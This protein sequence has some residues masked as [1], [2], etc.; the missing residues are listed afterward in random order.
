MRACH[1]DSACNGKSCSKMPSSIQSSHVLRSY[2]RICTV[3]QMSSHIE[4]QQHMKGT[5]SQ[6]R[7]E[8]FPLG[9]R[10]SHPSHTEADAPA[11]LLPDKINTQHNSNNH[12][13]SLLELNLHR[14]E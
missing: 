14:S 5:A 2:E 9:S 10:K 7:L 8:T 3:L 1:L 6:T 12:R 11:Y 13:V 4:D